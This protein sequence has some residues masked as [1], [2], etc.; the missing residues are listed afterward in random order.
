[1]N[2]CIPIND[3]KGKESQVYGHFGSAPLFMIYEEDGENLKVINNTNKHH[4]HGQC[5][6]IQELSDLKVNAVICNGMGRRAVNN[7][8]NQYVTK[9]YLAT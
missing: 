1:M 9:T 2:I 5:H 7:L 4:Q 8:Q 3:D 6:S